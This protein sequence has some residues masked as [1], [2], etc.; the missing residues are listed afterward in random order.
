[1]KNQTPSCQPCADTYG[2]ALGCDQGKPVAS[3]HRACPQCGLLTAGQFRVADGRKWHPRC[4][5]AS[6]SEV[7]YN[8]AACPDGI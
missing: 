1:M 4:L 6:R 7:N 3:P 5:D 2:D 8:R